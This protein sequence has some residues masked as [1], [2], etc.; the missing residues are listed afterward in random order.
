[1]KRNFVS[2]PI[3]SGIEEI[4]QECEEYK[5]C[6]FCRYGI[7]ILDDCAE[8]IRKGS[9]TT[10]IAAPN[11]GKSLWALKIATH[12]AKQGKKVLICSCEMGAGLILE[13]E[14]KNLCG[15][16]MSSLKE[17][18]KTR[19]STVNKILSSLIEDEKYSY[20]KNIIVAE[21]AG[22]TADDILKLIEIDNPDIVII[23]YIQRVVGSGTLYEVISNAF[24]EFQ[25]YARV[26]STPMIICSQALRS[27]NDEAT[28]GKTTAPDRLRG[29]GSGSIEEDS[30][31]GV[32]L[33]E[34]RGVAKR[35][36]LAM[37][38]KNRYTNFKNITYK[39]ELDERLN[40]RLVQKNV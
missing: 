8:G 16:S 1:M 25:T 22:A 30:D 35:I 33:V 26:T 19:E 31:V 39:Y 24:L 32:S 23:D 10:I 13:R 12:C 28:Q 5:Q 2:K 40:L 6:G 4:R 34:E 15:I 27:S 36:I 37:V 18:Y 17:L 11:T 9:L 14:L 21:T 20:Y 7:E 29:K 38:F 3:L